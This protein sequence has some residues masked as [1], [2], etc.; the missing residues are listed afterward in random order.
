M[1]K[2]FAFVPLLV[3]ALGG[4][5]WVHMAPGASAVRVV[6]SAPTGCEKRGEVEVAVKHSVAFIERND[7]RVREE[8]ET[9]ARNEAPGLGADTI[10]PLGGPLRGAQRWAAWRCGG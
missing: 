9:L 8:L 6:A 10:H 4:C 2:S 1:R 3:L 5:T 7:L